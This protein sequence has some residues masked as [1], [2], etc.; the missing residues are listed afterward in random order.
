MHMS[1]AEIPP[2]QIRLENEDAV[3]LEYLLENKEALLMSANL[4]TLSMRLLDA[5]KYEFAELPDLDGHAIS[6]VSGLTTKMI[7][8]Y[9]AVHAVAETG[10]SGEG[11]I[12]VRSMFEALVALKFILLENVDLRLSDGK[13]LIV[14]P[15]LPPDRSLRARLFSIRTALDCNR[16]LVQ[17]SKARDQNDPVVRLAASTSPVPMSTIESAIGPTWASRLEK[18]KTY[19]G[20]RTLRDLCRSLDMQDVYEQVYWILSDRS[21]AGSL[22]SYFDADAIDGFTVRLFSGPSEEKQ[23]IGGAFV[24]MADTVD[25]VS[26]ALKSGIESEARA[27]RAAFSSAS[28]PMNREGRMGEQAP[29]PVDRK[30]E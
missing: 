25:L 16:K 21:H 14:P 30:P 28:K 4:L 20:L 26:S 24:I 19:H 27:L 11:G 15:E 29:P 7:R 13:P 17:F 6:V 12:L 10:L 18:S 3:R 23:A 5:R 2:S 9:R 22:H 8:L 1:D